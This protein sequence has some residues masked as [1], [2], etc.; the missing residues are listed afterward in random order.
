MRTEFITVFYFFSWMGSCGRP[1]F[2]PETITMPEI[3]VSFHPLEALLV[4]MRGPHP[5]DLCPMDTV[6]CVKKFVE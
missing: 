5:V 2:W 4:N 6:R 3:L 1:R